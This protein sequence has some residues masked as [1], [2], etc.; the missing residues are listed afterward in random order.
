MNRQLQMLNVAAAE[1]KLHRAA[2]A[3]CVD[4]LKEIKERDERSVS[5]KSLRW[6]R[7]QPYALALANAEQLLKPRHPANPLQR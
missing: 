5:G 7:G 6:T 4:V 3:Q 2:L 1:H